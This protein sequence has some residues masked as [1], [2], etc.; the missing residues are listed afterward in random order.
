MQRNQ[1]RDV[2]M[3]LE[4]RKTAESNL[5]IKFLKKVPTISKNVRVDP[6]HSA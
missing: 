1:L 2:K 6:V 5:V 4:E 3:K